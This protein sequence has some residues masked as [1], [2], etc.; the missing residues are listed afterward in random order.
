M[1]T[2]TNMDKTRYTENWEVKDYCWGGW[3]FSLWTFPEHILAIQIRE[4]SFRISVIFALGKLMRLEFEKATKIIP[5]GIS[6]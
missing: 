2:Y 3:V 1:P 6:H 4:G 5:L